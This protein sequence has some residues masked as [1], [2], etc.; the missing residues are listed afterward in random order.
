[1]RD[2]T[3]IQL[4]HR[5]DADELGPVGWSLNLITNSEGAA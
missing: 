4:K 3:P 1:V 2:E 5:T